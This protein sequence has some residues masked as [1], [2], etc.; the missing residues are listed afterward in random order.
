MVSTPESTEQY[1]SIPLQYMLVYP[2]GADSYTLEIQLNNK[3][4]KELV[5]HTN[6][7]SSYDLYFERAGSY[8]LTC[9]VKE[10]DARYETDL[11]DRKSTRLNSSH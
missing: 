10:L 4:E 5:I 3:V 11:S 9:V 1:T 7:L 8:L 6:T 2:D